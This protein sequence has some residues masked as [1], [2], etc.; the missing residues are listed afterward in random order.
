MTGLH[1]LRT[2]QSQMSVPMTL[3]REAS[4]QVQNPVPAETPPDCLGHWVSQCPTP[5]N[6]VRPIHTLNRT[7]Y[8]FSLGKTKIIIYETQTEN[9]ASWK[10][11][12]SPPPPPPPPFFFLYHIQL[13]CWCQLDKPFGNRTIKEDTRE[14][15]EF[16]NSHAIQAMTVCV[17]S[18]KRG[19]HSVSIRVPHK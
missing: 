13:C 17:A 1:A 11:P 18:Q 2:V 8:L 10:M 15:S 9:A 12:P 14:W 3:E 6:C 19:Y 16:A 7:R 4:P 5:S